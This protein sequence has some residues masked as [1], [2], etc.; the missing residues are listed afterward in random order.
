MVTISDRGDFEM[1]ENTFLFTQGG[2]SLSE[3]S[4]Y[5]YIR[6]DACVIKALEAEAKEMQMFLCTQWVGLNYSMPKIICILARKLARIIHAP[7][8]CRLL[9]KGLSTYQGTLGVDLYVNSRARREV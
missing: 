8:K 2:K 6:I 4:H 7:T 5:I 9:S 1:E 3:T